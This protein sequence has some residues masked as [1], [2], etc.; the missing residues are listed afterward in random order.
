M[1]TLFSSPF[2][3]QDLQ[4]LH[5]AALRPR[6]GDAIEIGR[7]DPDSMDAEEDGGARSTPD[8][9]D[10]HDDD[11]D[12][13]V[14]DRHSAG[15]DESGSDDVSGDDAGRSDDDDDDR[16]L[17]G[18]GNDD[19]DVPAPLR[20]RVAGAPSRLAGSSPPGDADADDEEDDDFRP[21]H[22]RRDAEAGGRSGYRPAASF[23]DERASSNRRGHAAGRL[24]GASGDAGRAS[25]TG[26]PSAAAAGHGRRPVRLSTGRRQRLGVRRTGSDGGVGLSGFGHGHRDRVSL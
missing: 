6:I 10:D 13:D 26:S 4:S 7:D 11:G 8:G 14:D 24:S 16:G 9:D 22:R 19:D 1:F 15:G 2:I 21:R 25:A 17:G 18:G 23:H 5:A 3:F 12:P 20:H